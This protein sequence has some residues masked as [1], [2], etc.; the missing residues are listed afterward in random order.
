MTEEMRLDIL[1]VA[2]DVAKAE[3]AMGRAPADLGGHVSALA[4]RF[5]A[6]VAGGRG[7]G[8]TAQVPEEN[9]VGGFSGGGRG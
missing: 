1:C 9:M 8:S 6:Y 4:A 5:E 3:M 7:G 2:A